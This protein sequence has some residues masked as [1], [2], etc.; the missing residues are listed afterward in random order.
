MAFCEPLKQTSTRSRSTS[1]GTAASDATVSAT[2]S[3]PNSSATFRNPSIF[4]ST[5]VEV[6]PCASPTILIFLP[7]PARRTSSGS[8]GLPYGASTF[9]TFDEARVAISYMRSENTPFTATIA[10]SPSSS[11]LTTDASIPP[12]PEADR[13]SVMRFSVWKICRSRTCVSSMQPRNH[14]SMWPT[15]GVANARYTRGSTEDGPGVNISRT[16]GLSSPIGSVIVFVLLGDCCLFPLIRSEPPTGFASG[17]LLTTAE[18]QFSR[19]PPNPR[20]GQFGRNGLRGRSDQ[21]SPP[22]IK[23][24]AGNSRGSSPS[25]YCLLLTPT[26]SARTCPKE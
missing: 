7:L 17:D 26:R 11:T 1:S 25:E 9:V 15:S 22:Q 6:S 18:M 12:E 8:T 24:A 5:P 10:S 21:T 14:G 2:S 23:K 3:A 16:G 4:V 20:N 19:N 13:G